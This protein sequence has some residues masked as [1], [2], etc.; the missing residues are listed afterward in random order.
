MHLPSLSLSIVLASAVSWGYILKSKDSGLGSTNKGHDV[1]FSFSV[2]IICL[3]ST[4][5]TE[6]VMF[7]FFIYSQIEFCCVYVQCFRYP[8]SKEGLGCFPFFSYCE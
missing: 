5:L 2:C 8:S 3:S 4:H 6:N 1:M 7:S